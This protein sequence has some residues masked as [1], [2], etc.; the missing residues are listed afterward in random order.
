M[1]KSFYLQLK[2]EIKSK[3]QE[4]D[5]WDYKRKFMKYILN[6]IYTKKFN[7][8]VKLSLRGY[9]SPNVKIVIV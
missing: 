9:M 3:I 6:S 2:N 7:A 4:R 8:Y 1:K 5:N